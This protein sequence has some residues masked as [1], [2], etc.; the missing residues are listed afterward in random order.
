MSEDEVRQLIGSD[1]HRVVS[2]ASLECVRVTF[3]SAQRQKSF[4]ETVKMSFKRS[5]YRQLT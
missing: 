1:N 2:L 3:S 4:D 5:D